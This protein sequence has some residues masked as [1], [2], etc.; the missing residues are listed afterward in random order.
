MDAITAERFAEI[1]PEFSPVPDSGYEPWVT[2]V[3]AI[4]DPGVW[5]DELYEI[6]AALWI[7][8]QVT[9]DKTS[10]RSGGAPMSGPMSTK[11]VDKVAVGYDTG[12]VTVAGAGSYNAT[13]Y[14]VRF[15]E[16]QRIIGAGP[17]VV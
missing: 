8:H 1:L 9:M 7:A 17:I 13:S 14:G 2:A 12:A 5:G 11:R 6:G 15:L 16:F 3:R 10:T 4:V